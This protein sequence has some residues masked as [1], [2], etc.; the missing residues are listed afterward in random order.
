VLF[1]VKLVQFYNVLVR[2]GPEPSSVR[3]LSTVTTTYSAVLPFGKSNGVSVISLIPD[4]VA[5]ME[6]LSEEVLDELQESKVIIRRRLQRRCLQTTSVEIP[7]SFYMS[8]EIGKYTLTQHVLL[9]SLQ[10]ILIILFRF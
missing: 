1:L 3:T 7:T 2:G 6:F 10:L 8:Q 4:L 9:V 5:S